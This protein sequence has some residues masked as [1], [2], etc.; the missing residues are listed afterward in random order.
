MSF[1]RVGLLNLLTPKD[2][3]S[4]RI[5]SGLR[6]GASPRQALDL[7]APRRGAGPWP[8]LVFLYGGAWS[9]GDRRDFGFAGRWLAA[10]GY[11]VAVADYRVLPE[12]EYPTFLDD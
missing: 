6:Y 11:L 2:R 12:V 8:L 5:A 4:R 7:Y 10:R 1:S 9:Q 3:A